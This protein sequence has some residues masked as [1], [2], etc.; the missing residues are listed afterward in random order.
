MQRAALHIILGYR[1][2]SYKEALALFGIDSLEDRRV[3]L[4]S[5]FAHKAVKHDKFTKW[6]KVNETR[7]RTRQQQPKYCHVRARLGR[8]QK[9]P[10]SYL[11]EILNCTKKK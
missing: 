3:K 1:Y 6:F 5:K 2:S 8:Y 7:T 9:S 10:L 11:T 4:C